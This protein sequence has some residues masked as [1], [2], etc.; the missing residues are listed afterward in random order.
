MDVKTRNQ[1]TK[2]WLA[3]LPE[4]EQADYKKAQKLFKEVRA[5]GRQIKAAKTLGQKI[6]LGRKRAKL[7]RLATCL[8]PM[9]KSLDL[10]MAIYAPEISENIC[11]TSPLMRWLLR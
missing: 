10:T 11:T 9:R 1:R 6:S 4:Q 3:D 7:W 2:E 5:L 8:H